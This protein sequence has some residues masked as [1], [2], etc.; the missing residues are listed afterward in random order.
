MKKIIYVIIGLFVLFFGCL[1]FM[2]NGMSSSRNPYTY[3]RVYYDGELLGTIKSEDELLKYINDNNSAFKEKYGVDNIYKP[4]NLIIKSY[5]TYEG[6]VDDTY[7]VY[8]KIEAL[9]S[10]TLKGYE[11]LISGSDSSESVY[12][13]D[14]SVFSSAID[15]VIKTFVD[16]E[17]YENYKNGVSNSLNKIDNVYVKENISYKEVY[18]PVNEKIYTESVELAQHL[19]YGD[20]PDEKKVTVKVGDTIESVSFDNKISTGDFLLSNPEYNSVDNLLAVNTKVTIKPLKPS[21]NVVVEKYETTEDIKNYSVETTYDDQKNQ[22][23]YKVVRKGENGYERITRRIETIN[24]VDTYVLT[25]S[26]E[27]LKPAISQ[28]DVKGSKVISKVGGY[29][30]GWPTESG[31]Y[32]IDRYH[33]RYSPVYGTYE[34]HT[35]LDITGTGCYSKIYAAN[36]GEVIMANKVDN[37]SYGLFVAINHHNGYSTLYGHMIKV[38]VNVGDI[39][40]KGQVIGLMGSTGDSTGCHLHFELWSGYPWGHGYRLNPNVISTYNK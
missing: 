23:Y 8:K 10:F 18:I 13:L 7:S 3:Y 9:A 20:D 17:E 35:G 38:E 27:E 12:V 26:K 16:G 1:P 31:Y 34:L 21:I 5:K 37:G 39:V 22:Q 2:S 28:I 24:G 32:V 40:E 6:L 4:N 29:V 36:N 14:E 19:L 25:L 15:T 11:F 30:W 33:Y